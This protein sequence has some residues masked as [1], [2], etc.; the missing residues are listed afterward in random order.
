MP[1]LTGIKA[2]GAAL[3]DDLPP[4]KY[5]TLLA[6]AL[7]CGLLLTGCGK[8]EPAP[9]AN[10]AA[11]VS[12]AGVALELTANDSMKFSLTQFEVKAG[13]PVKVLLTNMGSMPK[14]AMGHN[15]VILQK[16]TDTRAF[17]DAAVGAAATNYI[18]GSLKGQVIA[19]TR[20]LGPKESDELTFTAPSE[21]G[22]YPFICSFPAHFVAGM[23]GT[24][25][26]K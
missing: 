19:H 8:N 10:S 7:A 4:M 16:G 9:S 22:E 25:V 23:K 2:A 3:C 26:V 1:T 14:A 24:M 5:T 15:L 11:A 13:Q 20:L 21:P 6:S 17:V 12:S 18:P